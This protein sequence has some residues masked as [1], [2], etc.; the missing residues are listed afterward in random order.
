[1]TFK[2]YRAVKLVVVMIL[3]MTVS[4]SV[5]RENYLIPVM[6]LGIAIAVLLIVRRKVK[7]IVADER[8]YEI[9]GKAARLAMQIFSWFAV[10]IML[11]LYAQRTINPSFEA[12]ATTLAYS[13]MLLMLLYALIFYYY[14]KSSFFE[15]KKIY[16]IVGLIIIM[17]LLFFAGL[18]LLSGEDGWLCKNRE[19]IKH[20]HPN[21]PAPSTECKK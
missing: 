21:F 13:V 18:R 9:S 5:A 12:V 11:L 6:A 14:F 4:M 20:G 8:D 16:L 19:W 3:A 7:E 2:Q 15:G 10:V 1:M 17:T